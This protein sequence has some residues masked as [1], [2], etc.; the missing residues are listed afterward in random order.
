MEWLGTKVVVT[1]AGGFIASHLVERLLTLGAKVTGFVRYNSRNDAGLLELLGDKKKEIRIVWGDIREL[2]T[3][4]DL[5]GG[6]E[7]VFHLAALVGIPYSYVHP[8]EV[9]E[10]NTIGTL[11]VLTAAKESQ[12]RRVIVTSTSEVYGTAVYVPMDEKHPRQPQSPYS[13]SKIAAD[14]IALSYYSSFNFP[15][16]VARPFNTYGPGQ[17]DRAIIPTIITQAL[18]RREIVLGSTRPTRDFNFV[19]D[20]VEG[21]IKIAE[22]DKALGQDINLGTGHEISVGDLAQKIVNLV[23]RQIPV[24]QSE[25]RLRPSKSEVERLLADSTKAKDL[26]GWEPKVDLDQGLRLTI[27]WVKN[28]LAMYDPDSYRI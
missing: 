7:I 1:G 18:T 4:R 20:T 21:F 23:G 12:V 19:S 6:N 8:N 25:E 14:A 24:R 28:Q 16:A 2:Q 26:V 27:D 17:S 5:V 15:V 3:V 9:I 13:A 22:S 11:N 10:V